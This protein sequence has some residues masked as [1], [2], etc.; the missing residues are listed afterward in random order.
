[1]PSKNG[2]AV[3]AD[4]VELPAGSKPLVLYPP[5]APLHLELVNGRK[6]L[7]RADVSA[8][9]ES[10]DVMFVAGKKGIELQTKE[11]SMPDSCFI[12]DV[13]SLRE[14]R[15]RQALVRFVRWS[16]LA[17]HLDPPYTIELI[18]DFLAFDPARP[19]TAKRS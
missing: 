11:D 12:T 19:P 18:N 9:F 7:Y 5:A 8:W 15:L 4:D 3:F 16:G 13:W 1:M 10:S 17:A 2:G 6:A 14:I